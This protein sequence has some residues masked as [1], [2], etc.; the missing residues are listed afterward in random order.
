MHGG[1]GAIPATIMEK[2]IQGI[3]EA[4]REGYITLKETGH[5]LDAVERA[6]KVMEDN[7]YFNSGITKKLNYLLLYEV[8]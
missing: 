7:G 3:Q 1:A 4:V 6:I 2:K 8:K 5:A